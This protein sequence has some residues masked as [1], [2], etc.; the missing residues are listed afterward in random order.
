GLSAARQLLNNNY[1]DFRLIE[2]E[3]QSGGNARYGSNATGRFP[4]G[5]HYLPLPDPKFGELI[6]FLKEVKLI[7]HVDAS[8]LP[9]YDE[10]YLCHDPDER[11]FIHGHWQEGLIPKFGVDEDDA[12]QLDRFLAMMDTYKKAKG[13]DGK[14]A[15]DIPVDHSSAD[16]TYRKLDNISMEAF[17]QSHGFNSP[18]LKWYVNYCC[19][20]DFGSTLQ[21]TS[22]WA[23]IHYFAARKGQASNADAGHVLTWPEGNGWLAAQLAAMCSEHIMAS[24]TAFAI[25]KNLEGGY[26]V[27]YIDHRTQTIKRV[28]ARRIIFS[29]PSFVLKHF[30]T[31]IKAL[32]ERPTASFEYSTWIVANA[33]VDAHHLSER[34]GFP[35]CWDNVIYGSASL[36]YINSSHQHVARHRPTYNFTWYHLLHD[37]GKGTRKKALNSPPS[38]WVDLMVQDVQKVY[39]T[40]EDSLITCDVCVWGHAMIKPGIGFI[41]GKERANAQQNI[42]NALFFAHTELSGMSIFEEGFTRGVDAA[43]AVLKSLKNG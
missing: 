34:N 6:D 5:A 28:V 29:C 19:K 12:L 25:H 20:D 33:E 43:D 16:D 41:W 10:K 23:G 8:G 36:G 32:K 3:D 2:L 31:N 9:H 37:S 14:Y 18:Y 39:S 26:E 15:F 21:E 11:L 4:L 27:D 7:T 42:D 1:K 17:L 30:K 38:R 24:C 22:A 40:F 13:F 35:L